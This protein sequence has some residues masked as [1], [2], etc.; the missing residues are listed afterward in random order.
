MDDNLDFVAH[1]IHFS[2]VK[3]QQPLSDFLRQ[4]GE[5][6][7]SLPE[8]AAVLGSIDQRLEEH[9][10]N[11]AR[12]LVIDRTDVL[13]EYNFSKKHSSRFPALLESWSIE[14]S[15]KNGKP[16]E[17]VAIYPSWGDPEKLAKEL[18]YSVKLIKNLQKS[19]KQQLQSLL[20][21][22]SLT[23]NENINEPI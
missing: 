8:Q 23:L 2:A 13:V 9:G 22:Y 14:F 18:S 4:H 5:W 6:P 16:L 7:L 3:I 11:S 1:A 12:L 21:N 19:F 10:V 20:N 15:S 17:V